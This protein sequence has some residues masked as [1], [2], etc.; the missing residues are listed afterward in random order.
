[1]SLPWG[2]R[3][4]VSTLQQGLCP[5]SFHSIHSYYSFI[6]LKWCVCLCPFHPFILLIHRCPFHPFVLLIHSIPSI[7]TTHSYYSSGVCACAHAVVSHPG[8]PLLLLHIP[9]SLLCLQVAQL[10]K[11]VR[12][13]YHRGGVRQE[14]GGK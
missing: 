8:L 11:Q 6:N 13:A 10:L 9:S 14:A 5:V 1:M 4:L 2:C 3:R 12:W 7:H